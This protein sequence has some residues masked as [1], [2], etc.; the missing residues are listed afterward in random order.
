M[1]LSVE[2]PAADLGISRRQLYN[3][4]NDTSPVTPKIALSLEKNPFGINPESLLRHQVV[5]LLKQERS[6]LKKE[7]DTKRSSSAPHR[8]V[9]IGTATTSFL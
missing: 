5:Y 8:S 3:I 4:I 6:K 9:K 1:D 7:G 2:D